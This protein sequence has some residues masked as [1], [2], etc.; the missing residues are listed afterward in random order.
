LIVP[1]SV[2]ASQPA[3]ADS[4]DAAEQLAKRYAPVVRLSEQ[5][6]PCGNGE[7]YMP[8]EV[9]A[10]MGN[11]GVAFRG[12][13][14]KTDLVKVAPTSQ[15]LRRGYLGYHL[16]F[17]GDAL[18]PGC[19]YEKWARHITKGFPSVTYA[20]VVT[21]RDRPGKVALQYWFFYV[22]NDWNNLH[23]GD[24]EM[25][26][27]IF[28]AADAA[29][30]LGTSPS[31]VGYSQHSSAER[32]EWGSEEMELVD[33][34]HP[35]VYPAEGS[36]AN[37]FAPALFLGR[38][39]RAGVGCDNTTAPHHEIRPRVAFVPTRSS[40]YL[41]DYPWLAF[42]G[43][44]GEQQSGFYNGPTG[45]NMKERWAE[46]IQWSE[47]RWRDSSA[48]VPLGTTLGPNANTFFCGSIETGSLL[49]VWLI[50]NPAIVLIAL[51]AL[52]G[53]ILALA[54]R[55]DWS[56]A[57]PRPVPVRRAWGQILATSWTVY[58]SHPVH[59]LGIGAIYLPVMAIA[60]V[61]Q[62]LLFELTG[63]DTLSPAGHPDPVVAVAAFV[64]GAVLSLAGYFWV[65]TAVAA[66]LAC[67]DRGEPLRL[68]AT[69]RAVR[70]R[71]RPL[72]GTALVLV[73]VVTAL[74]IPVVAIP[75]AVA[76]AV[77]RGFAVQSVML[78]NKGVYAALGR[79]RDLV[80]GQFWRVALIASMLVGTGLLL[81]PLTGV[82]LL[83]ASNASPALVNLVSAV[84]YT[85]AV[86][87]VALG[88]TYLYYDLQARQHLAR[89]PDD[90]PA[91]TSGDL[92][93]ST[94]PTV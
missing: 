82:A 49:V 79:S 29:D 6:E 28:D 27:V 21:E 32:T 2:A 77:R 89:R 26:Q 87:Y 57:N 71:V 67:L 63:V 83:L 3:A 37:F 81:G 40:E 20:H 11:S 50:R 85:V 7:P 9:D 30:A 4:E 48:V 24:W 55:T 80:R 46:P 62:W 43:R 74:A 54:A 39:S 41:Q 88:L 60:A 53:L 92:S 45:P 76:F 19:D 42:E 72:A 5:A 65:L 78:E 33:G 69:Y 90:A 75:L 13:W 34:T 59:F 1:P 64:A 73:A 56:P 61:L 47:N 84:I 10:L 70:E 91:R 38:D 8:S 17:P 23:E 31:Q 35:V 66:S 12:P 15:D 36:H 25:I 52:V 86:P 16:D 93:A 51:L 94:T 18:S 22:F 14:R 58:R 44:W 68:S